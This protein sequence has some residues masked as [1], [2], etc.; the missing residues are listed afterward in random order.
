MTTP[1][2]PFDAPKTEAPADRSPSA[3]YTR[4]G[5]T[6]EFVIACD[7]H[8]HTALVYLSLFTGREELWLDGVLRA[9]RRNLRLRSPSMSVECC[10]SSR[11]R[12]V[13]EVGGATPRVIAR[14]DGGVVF[15]DSL[16]RAIVGLLVACVL[17]V[18]ATAFIAAVIALV[19]A[20]A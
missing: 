4:G 19:A 10:A 18:A 6:M 16:A 13:V 5:Y 7:D 15:D 3:G 14:V 8:T 12:L 17:F 20:R 9:S 11:R 2:S 1:P